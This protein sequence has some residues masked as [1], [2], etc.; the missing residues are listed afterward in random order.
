MKEKI[1]YFVLNKILPMAENLI[2]KC[3]ALLQLES[4]QLCTRV[5]LY[6]QQISSKVYNIL[7]L[8][9]VSTNVGFSFSN[10]SS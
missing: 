8:H 4:S 6:S 9:Y 5:S 1:G 3:D 10:L 7:L 2:S